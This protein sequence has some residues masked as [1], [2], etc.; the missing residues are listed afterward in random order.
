MV[1]GR[2]KR[3]EGEEERRKRGGSGR[4][5]GA[6]RKKTVKIAAERR[7]LERKTLFEGV[8]SVFFRLRRAQSTTLSNLRTYAL[9]GDPS[10]TEK[11]RS[12]SDFTLSLQNVYFRC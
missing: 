8:F 7:F 4:A 11:H 12:E 2:G 10:R 6:R 9:Y 3:E 1:G 5:E